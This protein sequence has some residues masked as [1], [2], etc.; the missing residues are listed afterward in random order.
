MAF[1]D[2]PDHQMNVGRSSSEL[3]G[4]L[5]AEISAGAIQSGSFLLGERELSA[6]HSVARM[7]ARR[8]L[9]VL[10]AEGYLRAERGQGYRVLTRC[11]DP[12]KGCPIAFAP[13]NEESTAGWQELNRFLLS[14]LQVAARRRG[15]SVLGVG[16]AGQEATAIMEQCAA[17]RAWG[18]IADTYDP[19]LVRLAARG[20]LPL[21]AVDSWE[22]GLNVDAIFQNGF[23]GGGLAM[24]YLVGRGHRRIAWYGQVTKGP[25][26]AARLGGAYTALLRHGLDLPAELRVETGNPEALAALRRLLARPDRPTGVVALWQPDAREAHEVI[27]ELGLVGKVELVAWAMAEGCEQGMPAMFP[28]GPMPAMITWSLAEMVE[29]AIERLVS[30]RENPSQPA[31]TINIQTK[32]RLP[33]AA[34]SR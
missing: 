10:E 28:G 5:M 19:E 21:V 12:T 32:L 23:Q 27:R 13:Y 17:G 3:A 9:K 31:V 15:W 6:K 20:G 33:A 18:L 34:G 11:N 4:K 1:C 16:G 29:M 8:A 2:R 22:P 24:D 14:S 25:H 26:A 30:R 7:T